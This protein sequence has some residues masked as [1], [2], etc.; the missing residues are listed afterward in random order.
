MGGVGGKQKPGTKLMDD[1]S[2]AGSSVALIEIAWFAKQW[3]GI[4]QVFR[5]ERTARI[6]CTGQ[7]R[8]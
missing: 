2:I 8:H 1:W 3:H 5:L 6:L 7:I 4:E